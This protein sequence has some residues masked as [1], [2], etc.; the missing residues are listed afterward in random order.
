ML[1]AKPGKV[2]E[3]LADRTHTTV[4]Q[5]ENVEPRKPQ[6]IVNLKPQMDCAV[7]FID[8]Q[9]DLQRALQRA[10]Q[11]ERATIESQQVPEF[12]QTLTR[13]SAESFGAAALHGF[14]D[15]LRLVPSAV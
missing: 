11:S 9:I 15:L 3:L 6:R 4:L 7:Q 10:L 2:R 12:I 1:F 14:T 5:F 8:K 13:K